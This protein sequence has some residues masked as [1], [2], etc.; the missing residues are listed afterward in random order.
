MVDFSALG[1]NGSGSE[2]HDP[3]KIFN[4]LVKPEGVNE[5][6]ASQSDVLERWHATRTTRDRIIKLPTG[7]GKSL[8][9]LLI[10]QSTINETKLPALYLAPTRQLVQQV[11]TEAARFGI[12]AEPYL[13]SKE[14]LPAGFLNSTAIGVATYEAVFNGLSKFGT[15]TKKSDLQDLG[16]LILDDAHAAFESV[17]ESFTFSVSSREHP[18]LYADLCARFRSPFKQIGRLRTFDEVISGKE[19]F[20]LEVPH[21][22]WFDKQDE[23]GQA[24]QEY[25]P[26]KVDVWAWPHLRDDFHA[27]HALISKSGFSILPIVPLVDRSSAFTNAKRRVYMSAT[28][29][30][31]SEVV[32]TFGAPAKRV[33]E[34]IVAASLAGVGERM[35]LAPSLM[36]LPAMVKEKQ[37]IENLISEAKKENR[38]SVI[39]TTSFERAKDWAAVSAVPHNRDESES[40][41]EGLHSHRGFAAVLPRRYDGIDLPGE[42]C[43]VL[44][45]D[46]LPYGTTD[47]DSWRITALSQGSAN[48]ILAQR[49]EQ[50][51]GRA[52][53]GTSDYSV[54]VLTGADLI[55]WVGKLA[56]KQFLS[57]GTTRQLEIGLVV[58]KAVTSSK[59]FIE[60]A[61]QCLDRDKG[62]RQYHANEMGSAATP[63]ESDPEAL[64]MWESERKGVE[65][66]RSRQFTKALQAFDQAIDHAQ[67]AATKAWF[68]QLKAR[69]AY[70]MG[71][72]A[73]SEEWQAKA[74]RLNIALTAPTG[75]IPVVKMKPAAQQSQAVCHRLSGYMHAGVALSVFD[76]DTS[77]LTPYATSNQFE[78]ALKKL[79]AW[80]GFE[81]SRPD[82]MYK[83]G[84]D[85]LA[86]TVDGP[87][88]IVEAKSRKKSNNK[89]T[90]ALHAQV[91]AHENWFNVHY[92]ADA[93]RQRIVVYPSGDSEPNA[94]TAGTLAMTFKSL[95]MIVTDARTLLSECGQVAPDQCASKAQELLEQLKLT[96][97]GIT[98]RL[99]CF[100]DAA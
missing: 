37:L 79:F 46:G 18:E 71:D 42:D 44:V 81:S 90:K 32:R 51:I 33:A 73:R 65:E 94:T 16:I 36:Q 83:I 53:R 30:D 70:Q 99:E 5:L 19:H 28:I 84:P 96:P 23:V 49:I 47:Y 74:Y 35:I 75:Q 61:R 26:E 57:A 54:V 98:G 91:L 82:E 15:A 21:W 2:E 63:S 88:L 6:Y 48:S 29:A 87:A 72:K 24:I 68:H 40:F 22:A 92:G 45:M 14:G 38:N 10:A 4:A 67:D 55:N 89:L 100:S 56:N 31:D 93:N 86:M 9:G 66:L 85:V 59:E 25:G 3:R 8:V 27:C 50:G 13:N 76:E 11:C 52:S 78:E 41:I 12:E 69:T 1:S 77:Y 97:T 20:V 39:L 62:W 95:A 17:W 64:Q 60:T 43:R 58:S 7:G 34:P 80:I